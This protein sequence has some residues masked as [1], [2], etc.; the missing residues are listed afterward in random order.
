[1]PLQNGMTALMHAAYKG[2][3]ESVEI[4]ITHGADVNKK[5]SEHEVQSYD[6]NSAC[7]RKRFIHLLSSKQYEFS[8]N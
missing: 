7:P 5:S 2:D 8:F 3:V 1:M 6:I 4:L